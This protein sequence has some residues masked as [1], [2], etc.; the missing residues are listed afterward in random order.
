MLGTVSSYHIEAAISG[1]HCQSKSYENTD[2]QQISSLYLK[3][4]EYNRS[5]AVTVNYA[6]SLLMNNQIEKAQ[7]QLTSVEK[8]MKNYL[9][10]Y[11]V[12]AKASELESNYPNALSLYQTAL[13]LSNN[14]IERKF[15]NSKIESLST[16]D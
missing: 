11:M 9:P 6:A 15:I 3:L 12:K 8:L 1:L 2:W 14:Y 10:F 7:V 16:I 13:E 5:P 4:R